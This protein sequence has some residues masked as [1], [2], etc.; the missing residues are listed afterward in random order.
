MSALTDLLS[1]A[2]S[3][4]LLNFLLSECDWLDSE[5]CDSEWDW[6]DDSFF[7]NSLIAL[8][9][10]ELEAWLELA[11][12]LLL[13][14][15]A[16]LLLE[17][18]LFLLEL[19]L[20]LTNSDIFCDFSIRA[21]VNFSISFLLRDFAISIIFDLEAVLLASSLNF[22]TSLLIDFESTFIFNLFK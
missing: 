11:L 15:L 21:F 7:I 5:W 12:A 16:L 6:L 13:L 8:L 10:A 4:L 1:T 22:L 20:F 18:A 19:A 9:I 14:E 2:D 17:D 3:S